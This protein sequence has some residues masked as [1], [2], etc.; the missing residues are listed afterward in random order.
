VTREKLIYLLFLIAA[1]AFIL[2]QVLGCTT[3]PTCLD[4]P[5]N[6]SC[7]TADQLEKEL[8]Q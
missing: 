7:M 3:Q 4:N 1:L 5:R 2:W 6:M 8:N